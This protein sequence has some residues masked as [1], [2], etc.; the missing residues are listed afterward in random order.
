MSFLRDLQP[1]LM[2]DPALSSAEHEHALVGLSRLNFF[3]GVIGGMY[4]QI[5]RF[6]TK[7]R[8]LK[9]LDIASGS[10]DLPVA[11]AKRASKQGLDLEMTATDISSVAVDQQQQRAQAAGVKLRSLQA[12]CFAKELPTGFDIVTCS[13]FMHHLTEAQSIDLLRKMRKASHNAVIVCDL[14]RTRLNYA[15]VGFASRALTRSHVVHTDA[16]L[17]VKNAYTKTEFAELARTAFGRS[18]DV[19]TMFPSRFLMIDRL[20]DTESAT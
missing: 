4:R 16:L 20:G 9:V 14:D 10:G 11:W 13:L 3:S 8:P 5:A 19:K 1:E 2:D 12:D 15:L 6:A 7:D 17:S 18:V